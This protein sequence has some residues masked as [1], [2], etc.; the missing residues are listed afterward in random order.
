MI[1]REQQGTGPEVILIHGWGMHGGIWANVT[2]QLAQHYRVTVVDLP[3]HGHSPLPAGGFDLPRL[4][5][6][7]LDELPQPAHWVGWSL[8]GMIA[9]QAALLQP[10]AVN[11]LVTVASLPQFVRS[12]DWPDAMPRATLS[13]FINHLRKDYNT[14]LKRFLALQVRGTEN[15]RALL[16]LIQQQVA[17][18]PPPNPEALRLGLEI[19][20]NTDLRP[21][22]HRLPPPYHLFFGDRDMLVPIAAAE[23]LHRR[24]PMAGY[25]PIAK[26]GHAPFLS[27]S[28][29]FLS[30]LEK[31]LH[32]Q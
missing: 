8:G 12:D 32:Q 20:R 9:M 23:M 13:S 10:Q 17:N 7:L 26:A 25:H 28:D 18:R 27:H 15:E 14:T 31:L 29:I 16:R 21:Q 19:L 2:H 5:R 30:E 11:T 6:T 1:Y 24:L 3:G 22:L 4:A